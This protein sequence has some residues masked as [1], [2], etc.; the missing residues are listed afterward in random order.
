VVSFEN[1]AADL[2][3]E[4]EVLD[5]VNLVVGNAQLSETVDA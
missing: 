4:G 3:R 2:V 1:E 5:A